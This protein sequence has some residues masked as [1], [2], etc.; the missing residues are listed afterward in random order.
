MR[1][2][3]RQRPGAC[4]FLPGAGCVELPDTWQPAACLISQPKA[5]SGRLGASQQ[6]CPNQLSTAVGGSGRKEWSTQPANQGRAPQEAAWAGVQTLHLQ[7][8]PPADAAC[9]V[10][11]HAHAGASAAPSPPPPAAWTRLCALTSTPPA[12]RSSPP[13]HHIIACR[14]RRVAGTA[15]TACTTS[16]GLCSSA[17]ASGG[18]RRAARAAGHTGWLVES[19][20]VARRCPPLLHLR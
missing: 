18:L 10:R 16:G 11:S 14:Q 1:G 19:T 7:A 8:W 20:Q 13:T 12:T 9:T 3:D 4:R 15:C 2:R 6:E 17:A 5:K